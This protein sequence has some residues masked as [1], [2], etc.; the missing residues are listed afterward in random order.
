MEEDQL[1]MSRKFF[2]HLFIFEEIESSWKNF[3][4]KPERIAYRG[5]S[6]YSYTIYKKKD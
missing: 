3:Y 1:Q 4:D 2:E 5:G 6:G